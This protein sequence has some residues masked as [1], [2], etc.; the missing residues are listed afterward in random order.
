M[1]NKKVLIIV[2]VLVLLLGGFFL[3]R[4]FCSKNDE[5]NDLKITYSEG[6]KIS[7]R[8]L[9]KDFKEER[10]I[11]V[12][13]NS[14][15]NKTYSLEWVKV[16]NSLKKQNTFLYSIK[17]TGDRCAELG[18]SQV[19]V[20]GSNV[21]TQVLIEP[22]K[23]QTYTVSFEYTGSEKK[24][25]FKGMLQVYSKKV[26]EKKIEKEQKKQQEEMEK[27]KKEEAKKT[28]A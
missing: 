10:T 16:N 8:N 1:K 6:K 19:P 12:E 15:E 9:K 2:L 24:A 11:T 25:S 26:D 5:M 7:F 14:K 21:Y 28:K 27:R 13:N 20:A 22:G 18:K 4:D 3:I 17:C 23:K